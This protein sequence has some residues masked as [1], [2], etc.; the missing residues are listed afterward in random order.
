[1]QGMYSMLRATNIKQSSKDKFFAMLD[2]NR[3]LYL[4]SPSHTERLMV[5]RKSYFLN[6]L[7]DICEINPT[8][9]LSEWRKAAIQRD[10]DLFE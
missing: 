10:I 8:D 7:L 6:S 1:M 9:E 4:T 2:I 5:S 3:C